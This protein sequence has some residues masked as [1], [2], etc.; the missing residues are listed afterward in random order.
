MKRLFGSKK[1]EV[2]PPPNPVE[3]F[4]I[5]KHHNKLET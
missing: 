2:V 5:N 4:D 1:K 3:P